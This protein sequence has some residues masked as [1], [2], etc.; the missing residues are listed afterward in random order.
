MST[1]S[2]GGVDLEREDRSMKD[3]RGIAISEIPASLMSSSKFGRKSPEMPSQG[4]Q[5]NEMR[6]N[7]SDRHLNPS[8]HTIVFVCVSH[9]RAPSR[10]SVTLCGAL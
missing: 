4:G 9:S 1:S 6:L 5:A 7:V 2:H 3:W 10:I 8:T